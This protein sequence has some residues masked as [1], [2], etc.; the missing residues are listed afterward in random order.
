MRYLV[1]KTFSDMQDD[2]YKYHVGDTFPHDGLTVSAERIEELSTDKNRRKIPV[3]KAEQEDAPVEEEVTS[4]AE[5][6][7]EEETTSDAQEEAPA[8]VE[9]KEAEKPKAK[10]RKRKS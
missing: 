10:P 3:I 7:E 9:E 6:S 8:P 5:I 2:G 4:D 1:I